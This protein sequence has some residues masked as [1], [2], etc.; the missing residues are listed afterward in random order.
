MKEEIKRYEN[1][2]REMRKE[3]ELKDARTKSLKEKV[4]ELT[5]SSIRE[6]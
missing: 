2:V 6:G 5:R 4:D 1:N 3:I